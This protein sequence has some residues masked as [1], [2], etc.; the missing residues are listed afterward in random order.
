M[1][2]FTDAMNLQN[3]AKMPVPPTM[4]QMIYI[5]F[6][7]QTKLA[8]EEWDTIVRYSARRVVGSVT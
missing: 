7:L 5:S 8:V 1:T 2:T 4:N 3:H 6:M